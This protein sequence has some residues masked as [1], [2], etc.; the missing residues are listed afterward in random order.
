MRA[1]SVLSR[2]AG[3]DGVTQS[4]DGTCWLA[5]RECR[6]PRDSPALWAS[7]CKES[8][9]RSHCRACSPWSPR[10][11]LKRCSKGKEEQ[12]QSSPGAESRAHPAPASTHAAQNRFGCLFFFLLL[13]KPY[14]SRNTKLN[15]S[16]FVTGWGFEV[17]VSCFAWK[18]LQHY[19]MLS[20]PRW[21]S[22]ALLETLLIKSK[23]SQ[24]WRHRR[25]LLL[26]TE[27][28]SVTCSC[29]EEEE[30]NGK[31]PQGTRLL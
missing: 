26:L 22:S 8:F 24:G 11:T 29:Q 12:H 31:L 18:T 21:C 10:A 7:C 20:A 1:V 16:S 3:A 13:S 6:V 15:N 2:S 27:N 4:H 23:D 30:G 25:A 5:P 28:Y 9:L 19:C 14:L 17:G